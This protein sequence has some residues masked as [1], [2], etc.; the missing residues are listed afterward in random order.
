MG[1]GLQGGGVGTVKFLARE[2]AKITVTDLRPRQVL[3]PAL[4]ALRKIRGI[5]WVLGKHRSRDF[6]RADIVVK[7]PGVRPDNFYLKLA[8]R[9]GIP[10]TSDIGIFF[11]HSPSTIIG[12]TGTR[13][14]STTAYLIWKFLKNGRRRVFLGGNIRTSVLEFLPRLRK[15][16]LVV[17]E[18]S[19]FQLADLA[20]DKKSPSIAV[21][22]NIYRDHL[23]WHKN[24]NDYLKA[25][26]NIFKFQQ[27]NDYLFINPEDDKLKKI[28]RGAPGR[29]IAARLPRRL[30][31]LVDE[32]LGQHYRPAVALAT[33]VAEHLGISMASIRRELKAFRGLEGRQEEIAKIRGVHFIN[34]TT[35]TI[36]EATIAALKRFRKLARKKKLILIAGGTDKNLKFEELA[37]AIRRYADWLILLP[38]TATEKIKSQKFSSAPNKENKPPLLE[39]KNM[40][41]AVATAYSLAQRGDYIL[42]SP[43]AA[44]F[45]LFLNEFDRGKQF[46]ASVRQLIND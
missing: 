13:G 17:V 12:V 44:S 45:G 30:R 24:F 42:L 33:A 40:K 20:S 1:L 38:G 14:K 5:R 31:K 19:S 9:H 36:P 10:V 39:V 3:A 21:C 32:K 35:A 27:P 15:D 4:K 23:N 16:D 22:T 41:E 2:G 28:T 25:K 11:R 46:V 7:N 6:V 26:S 37:G 18:L 8:R 29:I 34:D 43:G